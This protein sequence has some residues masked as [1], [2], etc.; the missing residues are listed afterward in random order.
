MSFR[1]PFL[2]SVFLF[3][4]GGFLYG[5]IEMLFKGSTHISMLIAGGFAFLLIGGLNEGSRN[6]SLLGMMV[7]SCLLITFIELVTGIIVNLWLHLNVWDYSKLPYN[8]L[9][10]VCLVFSVCWF[11]LSFVAILLDDYI[12]YFLL[13]GKKPHYHFM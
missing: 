1:F 9:G 11:L 8:F 2:K 10:Q 13:D 4:I 7:I 12:R 5:I 3:L 6:P